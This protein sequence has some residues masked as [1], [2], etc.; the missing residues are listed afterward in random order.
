[1]IVQNRKT[2]IICTIGPASRDCSTLSQLIQTGA[3]IFRFN[4]KYNTPAGHGQIIDKARDEAKKLG[5][6]IK[7]LVDLPNS[8]FQKGIDLAIRKKADY[9]ALSHVMQAE[10]AFKVRQIISKAKLSASIIAKIE[11]RESLVNFSE[12]LNEVDDV[13][14]A[15]GDLGEVI[16]IEKIP[17]VQKELIQ[18]CNK[19]GKMIIV[20]TEMLLSMISNKEPSR[21]EVSDVANAVLEGSNMVMLSEETAIGRYPVESIRIMSKVIFEAE[22]WKKLGHLEIFMIKDEKFKFGL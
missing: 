14:V 7:I 2:K 17:F 13:M 3:D 18:V 21:A 8:S 1:M 16:P 15:R 22:S 6:K 12:I 9:I 10:E 20:A 19:S 11:T 5:R 4:L